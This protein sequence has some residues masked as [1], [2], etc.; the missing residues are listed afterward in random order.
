MNL[1][2]VIRTAHRLAEAQE[3]G[4]RITQREMAACLGVSSRAYSEYQSGKNSPL[5]MKALL[6]LLNRL[7]DDEII[8]L[9]REY[10]EDA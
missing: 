4:R 1:T 9:V 2:D 7:S 6:R 3:H 5:G 8:R 10:R